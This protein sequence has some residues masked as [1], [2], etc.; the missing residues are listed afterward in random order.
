MNNIYLII[1]T[2][3][4]GKTWIMTQLMNAL[5]IS[6]LYTYATGQYTYIKK[7]G[8]ILLGRYDGSVFEGSD[9]LSMSIMSSN[10]KIEP[11]FK[12]ARFVIAEG[13]RF[14]NN[15]FIQRFKPIILK[16]NGDGAEGRLKRGSSQTERHLKSI[17]TRVNNINPT[18]EFNNSTECFNYLINT[19][20]EQTEKS[21]Q[22]CITATTL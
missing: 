20:N 21:S 5:D 8:I 3:G 2:C 11:I 1:G 16:V 4:V 19:I 22:T 14:T 9:R 17:T 13:D 6:R 7:N 12:Q 18:L 10:D 15:T